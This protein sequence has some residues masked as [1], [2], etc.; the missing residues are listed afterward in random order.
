MSQSLLTRDAASSQ[1]LVDEGT[2]RT[3]G[4]VEL[5]DNVDM[6][7]ANISRVIAFQRG[8]LGLCLN[9]TRNIIVLGGHGFIKVGKQT[10]NLA[11]HSVIPVM[12]YTAVELIPEHNQTVTV[13]VIGTR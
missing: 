2:T 9:R 13:M 6:A 3:W 12:P 8:I 4:Q 5:Y 7:L 10:F 1:P 11:L